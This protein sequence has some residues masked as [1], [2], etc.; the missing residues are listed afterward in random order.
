MHRFLSRRE[1]VPR[2]RRGG[3]AAPGAGR[4]GGRGW[5]W[6][7]AAAYGLAARGWWYELVRARDYGA[8]RVSARV[9]KGVKP[10]E[11]VFVQADLFREEGAEDAARRGGRAALPGRPA[12]GDAG[13]PPARDRKGLPAGGR[14]PAG[15]AAGEPALPAVLHP[16]AARGAAAGGGG[17]E[18]A[19]AVRR[20]SPRR[21]CCS[22][23]RRSTGRACRS[24]CA[25]RSRARPEEP[26]AARGRPHRRHRHPPPGGRRRHPLGGRAGGD[27]AQ[28]GELPLPLRAGGLLHPHG[29]G[30][31]RALPDR[32]LPRGRA[33][34][35]PRHGADRLRAEG[36]APDP[37]RVGLLPQRR[38]RVRPGGA[39]RPP[40]GK[41]SCSPWPPGP[42]SSPPSARR[43]RTPPSGCGWNRGWPAR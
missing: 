40:R 25:S 11:R 15:R 21:P 19:G 41:R 32:P 42:T 36:A 35:G 8:L 30:G 23:C 13:L 5:C 10:P 17:R 9:H 37:G 26:A 4:G 29:R 39:S 20:R 38:P 6:C 31:G 24:P 3:T 7:G 1:G 34:A 22:R 43:P 27:D 16:A 33:G 2:R 18:G 12:A 28:R 14:V